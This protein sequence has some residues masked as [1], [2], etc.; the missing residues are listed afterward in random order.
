MRQ[1]V[2]R[3]RR[4]VPVAAR[5]LQ[6]NRFT[7]KQVLIPLPITVISSKPFLPEN[8]KRAIYVKITRDMRRVEYGRACVCCAV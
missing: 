1:H 5:P 7:G 2:N 3:E 8:P 6:A 4:N